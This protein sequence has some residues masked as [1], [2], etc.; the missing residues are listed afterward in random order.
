MAEA[1]APAAGGDASGQPPAA[2]TAA[3]DEAQAQA[4]TGPGGEGSGVA[5]GTAPATSPD[6]AEGGAPPSAEQSL[7]PLQQQLLESMNRKEALEPLELSPAPPIPCHCGNVFGADDAFCRSCGA[8]RPGPVECTLCGTAFREAAD[9]CG[10]CG[11]KRPEPP[12]EERCNG[13]GW[14]FDDG[15]PFCIKC[16]ARRPGAGNDLASA[17][18]LG[19]KYTAPP[20]AKLGSVLGQMAATLKAAC[21]SEV[22]LRERQTGIATEKDELQREVD[23]Y[24]TE[25]DMA[26]LQVR[27]LREEVSEQKS[28]AGTPVYSPG[29]DYSPGISPGLGDGSRRSSIYTAMRPPSTVGAL[30]SP[31]ASV[32]S[33]RST[34]EHVAPSPLSPATPYA[35]TGSPQSTR[36]PLTPGAP[37]PTSPRSPGALAAAQ[38]AAKRNSGVGVTPGSGRKPSAAK[39][40][41]RKDLWPENRSTP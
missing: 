26:W 41:Q 33:R 8:R 1:S 22:R 12:Q 28:K 23:G 19:E 2:E 40:Q 27:R 31:A 39:P 15:A 36:P 21:D 29:A 30:P 17:V 18:Q 20:P 32:A 37:S 24:R 9:F 10:L 16:G 25:S 3:G 35:A 38:L 14:V 5:G 4:A 13:C 6:V 34:R 7:D 11:S